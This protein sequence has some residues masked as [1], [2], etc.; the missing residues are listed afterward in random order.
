M[1]VDSKFF[2][3]VKLRL[4]ALLLSLA[5]TDRA[6]IKKDSI[7][8]IGISIPV[9]WNNS[10]ATFYRLGS[11]R[12]PSGKASSYGINI[13]CSETIF[14]SIYGVIGIGYFK[15]KFGIIRPFNYNSPIQFGWTTESYSYDNI[16][17]SAGV[18]YNFQIN[19]VFSIK[20]SIFYNQFFSFRQKYINHSPISRPQVNHEMLSTGSTFTL[21]IG[22]ER[23]ITKRISLGID[24][25]APFLIR[26]N[27]DEIFSN[28]G[29]SK[30]ESQIA[31]NKSSF[32]MMI[33]GNY[34]F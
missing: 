11:P 22:L 3:M 12:Y 10:E 8:T 34:N 2:I 16:S 28:S 9:I 17:L 33:S 30:D 4:L 24:A 29:Y 26:W 25:L 23:S 7:K 20:S 14:K 15:Q 5:L 27:N 18:G 21:K 32:G 31:S 1:F 6:Q 13:N 19:K